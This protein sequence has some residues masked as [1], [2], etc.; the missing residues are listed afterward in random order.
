MC[1]PI[2]M[3]AVTAMVL[4]ASRQVAGAES[5]GPESNGPEL[6]FI[7]LERRWQVFAGSTGSSSL[8]LAV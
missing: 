8:L 1:R 3:F 4:L 2:C 6:R 5:N 7:R